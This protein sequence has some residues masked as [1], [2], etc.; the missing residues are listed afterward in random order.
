MGNLVVLQINKLKLWTKAATHVQ[1]A[2]E[3]YISDL[4][5]TYKLVRDGKVG[6]QSDA[7]EESKELLLRSLQKKIMYRDHMKRAS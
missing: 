2:I 4:M 3:C 1:G 7:S 6:N 5:E